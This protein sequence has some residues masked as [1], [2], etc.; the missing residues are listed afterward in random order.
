MYAFTPFYLQNM[1]FKF[2][3]VTR[4]KISLQFFFLNMNQP[5]L[6]RFHSDFEISDSWLSIHLIDIQVLL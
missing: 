1:Q 5:N 3:K 4:L 6:P 2:R